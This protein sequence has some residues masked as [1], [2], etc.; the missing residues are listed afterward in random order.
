MGM[1]H[2]VRAGTFLI[3]FALGASATGDAPPPKKGIPF[4]QYSRAELSKQFGDAQV[5]WFYNYE[6][7]PTDWQVEW[8]NANGIE[9][10]PMVARDIIRRRDGGRCCFEPGS[11]SSRCDA[12]EPTCTLDEVSDLLRTTKARM[13]TT[14]VTY[15][16]GYNEPYNNDDDLQPPEA[17]KY[18]RKFVQPAAE[19]AGLTL[20]SPTTKYVSSQ[21]Q[22]LA[23]FLMR[24]YDARLL[25]RPCTVGKIKAFAVHSYDCRESFW[26]RNYARAN[27]QDPSNLWGNLKRALGTYGG[28]DWAKYVDSRPLWVTETNCFWEDVAVHPVSR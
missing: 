17:V 3:L 12:G 23:Q 20:V 6:L 7:A 11:P 25:Q 18:W 1:R 27:A 26:E 15:L 16:L 10:V 9:F 24:C 28:H 14:P 19:D 21:S 4:G 5:S 22:W 8:A 13:T 2:I